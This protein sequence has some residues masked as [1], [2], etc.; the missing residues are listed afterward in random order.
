M[1]LD[2]ILR[3]LHIFSAIVLVGG[4][5]YMRCVLWPA[6]TEQG[7]ETRQRLLAAARPRW[8]RIVMITS[9][10]LLLSGL[11]NAVRII[12]DYQL[13]GPVR[14]D[15]LVALKLLLAV[16]A[17][18]LAAV[19]SGRSALAERCRQILAF[20]LNLQLL[21]A[22]LLVGLAGYMKMVPRQLKMTPAEQQNVRAK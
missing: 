12:M 18:G 1:A 8:S 14:Y 2:L 10:L 5:F 20:W 9:A 7:A 17:M 16:V 11:F 19:L 13:S 3:W 4:A 22:V 21:L 15:I 6:L